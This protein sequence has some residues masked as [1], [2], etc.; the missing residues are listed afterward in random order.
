MA[1]RSRKIRPGS[2]LQNRETKHPA[3]VM[4]IAEGWAMVRPTSAQPI[5]VNMREILLK[6]EVTKW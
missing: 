2:R 4:T 1:D 5:L 3:R 6:Y